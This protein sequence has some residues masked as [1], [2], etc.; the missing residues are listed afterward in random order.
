MILMILHAYMGLIDNERYGNNTYTC[1]PT[2]SD[3]KKSWKALLKCCIHEFTLAYLNRFPIYATGF[4]AFKLN[5]GQNISHVLSTTM[6]YRV[7]QA[8]T[9]IRTNFG[10]F[11]VL[12]FLTKNWEL[13]ADKKG[14]FLATTF[15]LNLRGLITP[16]DRWL[17]LI[18][19]V[20]DAG[21][22]V[23][24]LVDTSESESYGRKV[25]GL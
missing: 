14:D 6:P 9:V 24:S 1:I 5:F 22:E 15:R 23:L 7:L 17:F 16:V 13:V 18:W 4:H 12:S 2:M 11:K 19:G 3:Q 10:P 20:D 25:T 21:F 8:N